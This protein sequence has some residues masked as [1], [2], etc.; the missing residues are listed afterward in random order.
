MSEREIDQYRLTDTEEPTDEMLA[1][2]M[3]E[4]A[5]E[6]RRTNEEAM[7]RYFN[8]ISEIYQDKYGKGCS[9]IR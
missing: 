6:A 5:E 1:Y 2:I 8:E 7:D 4:V 3:H 9:S